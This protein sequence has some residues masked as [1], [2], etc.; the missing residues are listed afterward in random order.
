MKGMSY[1][2]ARLGGPVRYGGELHGGF[3][4]APAAVGGGGKDQQAGVTSAWVQSAGQTA[5]PSYSWAQN[6]DVRTNRVR[7]DA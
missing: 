7:A 2:T 3:A 1:V 5:C 6:L 4:G